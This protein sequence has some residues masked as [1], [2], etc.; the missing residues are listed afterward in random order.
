MVDIDIIR[1]SSDE[2]YV[3]YATRDSIV[4]ASNW[5]ADSSSSSY[6]KIL[7]D[8]F[9]SEILLD[10]DTMICMSEALIDT[11]AMFTDCYFAFVLYRKGGSLYQV[12]GSLYVSYY[13]GDHFYNYSP[14]HL[15]GYQWSPRKT[16]VDELEFRIKHSFG[17]MDADS[18]VTLDEICAK[19][20]VINNAD[21]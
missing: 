5:E 18:L 17:W 2:P 21:A 3:K 9:M 7:E 4:V 6:K 8:L 20:L 1:S 11:D 16:S 14:R 15:L 10:T 19:E 13:Y 12:N